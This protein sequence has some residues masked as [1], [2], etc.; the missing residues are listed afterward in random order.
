MTKQMLKGI[1]VNSK[2]E[3]EER[4]YKYF[5]EVNQEPVVY[6]WTYKLDEISAEEANAY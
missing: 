3:L 5:D 4:I 6:R 1:R 2:E